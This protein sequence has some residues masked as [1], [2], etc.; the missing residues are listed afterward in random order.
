MFFG[1]QDMEERMNQENITLDEDDLDDIETFTSG[2]SDA[3]ISY[4]T[5]ASVDGGD[6]DEAATYTIAG[7]KEKIMRI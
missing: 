3:T 2:I 5:R 4:T 1:G 7:V 6:L